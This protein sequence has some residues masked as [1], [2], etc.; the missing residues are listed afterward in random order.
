MYDVDLW[1]IQFW[2]DKPVIDIVATHDT[3]IT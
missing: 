2:P 1:L 3:I